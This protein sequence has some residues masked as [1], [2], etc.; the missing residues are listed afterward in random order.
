M[1]W[2]SYHA[3]NYK[4]GKVDRVAEVKHCFE[5]GEDSKY[6]ILKASLVG[7]T[8]YAAVE[9]QT[10]KGTEVFA[11][12]VLTSVDNNDYFNFSYKD[13][14]ETCGPYHYDCPA[15]ILKL[16]TPTTSE[17]A[18]QWREKCWE[19][20]EKK[21]Q[22]KNDPQALSNLPLGTVIEMNYWEPETPKIR[23]MKVNYGGYKQPIWVREDYSFKV[24]P[25]LIEEQGYIV[26]S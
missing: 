2:T 11:A 10:E 15:S 22:K 24:R 17:H 4:N 9:Y 5:R 7:T 26:I 1:G 20:I 12:V 18:N 3:T 23:L 6:R 25:K 14:D 21:R 16:L 8:V 13:M 19:K